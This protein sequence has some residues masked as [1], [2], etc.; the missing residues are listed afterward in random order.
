MFSILKNEAKDRLSHHP[1]GANALSAV[2]VNRPS[3][4]LPDRARRSRE[5]QLPQTWQVL[6]DSVKIATGYF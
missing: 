5:A 2:S 1:A 6:A 4:N 3:P